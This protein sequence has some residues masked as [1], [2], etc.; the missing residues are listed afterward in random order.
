[1][2]AMAVTVVSVS[3][4]APLT[5]ASAPPLAPHFAAFTTSTWLTTVAG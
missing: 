2:A 4:T 3:A 1:M 5:V